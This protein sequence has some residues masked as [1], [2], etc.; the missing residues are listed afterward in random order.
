MDDPT[1]VVGGDHVADR[2]LATVEIDA[3]TDHAGGPAERR[4]GVAPVGLVVE[5]DVGIRLELLVDPRRA[6]GGGVRAMDVGERPAAVALL[7]DLAEPAR[8]LDQQPADDH[9]RSARDGR[10]GVGNERRVLRRDVDIVD[11]HAQLRRDELGE[12]RLRPLPHLRRRGEDPDP[13]IRPKL[14]RGDARELH[15]AGSGE[16]GPVPGQGEAD[17]GGGPIGAGPEW[18]AGHTAGAGAP[19]PGSLGAGPNA[20]ELGRLGR[21]LQDLFGRDALPEDLAG[22]RL[23]THPVEVAPPDVEGAHAE[24]VGD[25]P[26]LDLRGELNLRRAEPPEG[27]VRRRVRPGRSCPDPD[28]RAA[29]R[30]TG[31]DRPATQD[32]GRQ[33]AVRAAVHHDVDLLGDECPVGLDAGPV[34]DDRGVALRRRRQVLVAVVDHPDGLAGLPRQEGGVEGDDRWVLLLAAEAAAGLGLNDPGLLVGQA[35]RPLQRLVDVVRA[36]ERAV[37]CHAAVLA[38]DRDHRIVLD[39]ELLLVTD[40][41]LALD[42][43]VRLGESALE[44][45][46]GD[47]EVGEDV[48]REARVEDGRER[49]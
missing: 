11:G 7:D 16:A 6:V 30:S 36:L 5:M 38:G 35:Q 25:P 22:R 41:V 37:D 26:D 40:A 20:L 14:D 27:T 47:V 31:V 2:H 12:D 39:V 44:V 45:A 43:E 17:A 49:R 3:D 9:R 42:H 33:G 46:R 15:L 29:I 28:V 4:I 1:D 13:A 21:P 10:P 18:R 34:A 19:G 23:I 32:D 24:G 48:V 8:R